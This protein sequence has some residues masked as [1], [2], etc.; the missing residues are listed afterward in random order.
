MN[1]LIDL[2]NTL[3]KCFITE[4][5]KPVLEAKFD[6]HDFSAVEKFVTGLA[7]P[8]DAA[9]LSSVIDHPLSLVQALEK[10]FFT[11]VLDH[12]TSL[13]FTNNYGSPQTLGRDRLAA[14]A[15]AV[16]QYPG[17]NVLAI[18]AGTCIKYDLVTA[19]G[20]YLGGGIS[21]GIEM[22]FR[23]LNTFTDK[24]P[25][26]HRKDQ[27]E[28]LGTNTEGSIR[29][30]VQHGAMEEVKGMIA[31]YSEGRE[32]LKTVITG[33]DMDFFMSLVSEKNAIFA[34][35]YLALKGLNFIL[36]HNASKKI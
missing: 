6:A 30:G 17:S 19:D 14:A 21:P 1:L 12:T 8:V 33:G 34:D 15:G 4:Q 36:E 26:L 16:R 23:S 32:G 35:P 31:R 2:G 20:K 27:A 9:I 11:V 28:L 7:L 18:D 24:L 29:S 5:D 22:R 25:L 10:C 3:A 13:P